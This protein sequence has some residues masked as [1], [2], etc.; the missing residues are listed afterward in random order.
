[1]KKDNKGKSLIADQAHVSG[2]AAKGAAVNYLK[3]WN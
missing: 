1:M 3:L 2:L